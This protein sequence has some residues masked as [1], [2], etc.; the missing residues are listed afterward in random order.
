MYKIHL[1]SWDSEE[2]QWANSWARQCRKCQDLNH[3]SLPMWTTGWWRIL[4]HVDHC[5]VGEA[6]PCGPQ[7]SGSLPMWTTGWCGRLTHINHWMVEETYPCDHWMV[8]IVYPSGP[9]DNRRVLSMWITGWWRRF[10]HVDHWIVGESYPCE[11]LDD[12]GGLP[13]WNTE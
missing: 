8:E 1:E 11:P 12:E 9:L 5:M 7:V 2:K 6:Y 10:T 4:T 13:I 3:G